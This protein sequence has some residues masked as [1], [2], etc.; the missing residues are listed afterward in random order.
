MIFSRSIQAVALLVFSFLITTGF[1]QDRFAVAGKVSGLDGTAL[2]GASVAIHELQVGMITDEQ[3]RFRF[4]QL[5]PGNYHLHV[6]YLGYESAVVDFRILNEDLVLTIAMHPTSLE[7]KEIVV[8]DSHTKTREEA[9]S[10]SVEVVDERFLA[11]NREAG[12]VGSLEKI[13]GLNAARIGTGAA[14]P[15]IRGLG[16]NRV[17]VAEN[18]IKQEGQQWGADHGLEIDPFGVG[19]VELIKGPAAVMYGSDAMG[20]VLQL[21]APD[22]PSTGSFRAAMI[23]NG[24]TNTDLLGGSIFAEGNK[25]GNFFRVRYSAKEFGDIRVPADS[26]NYQSFIFPVEAGRLKNTAGSERSWAAD[27]GV[28]REWGVSQLRFSRFEQRLGFFPGA[29]GRPNAL[30]VVDDGDYR[31]VDFPRQEIN[32]SKLIWNTNVQHHGNWLEADF[33]FQQNERTEFDQG[34]DS[35]IALEALDLTLQTFSGNLKYHHNWQNGSKAVYGVSGFY[36]DN[37]RG[38]FDFLIPDFNSYGV[39]GYY[40]LEHQAKEE[41]TVNAGVRVDAGRIDIA[42]FSEDNQGEVLERS[43]DLERQFFNVSGAAGLSWLPTHHLNVKFNAGTSFRYP[44]AAELASNG[45]HHGAFR[46]E[47]G[48][49]DLEAERGYQL[50]LNV[51]YHRKNYGVKLSP[52]FNFFDNY[53]YLGPS[54]RFASGDLGSGHIFQYRQTQAVHTGTELSTDVHLHKHVHLAAVAE[55]VWAHNLEQ[56]IP[57]PLIPPFKLLVEA[58]YEM[59]SLLKGRIKSAYLRLGTRMASAQN[60]VDRNEDPTESYFLVDASAGGDWKLGEREIAIFL[61]VRNML[62]QTYFDH[63]SQFRP[64]GLPGPGRNVNISIQ[65]PLVTIKSQTPINYENA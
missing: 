51:N 5:K 50:D 9:G 45:E 65:I 33:G 30:S 47:Q 40:F 38:G 49:P 64:L 36:K 55:Y 3:G 46:F 27:V 13:P 7:F 8:E 24:Q 44:T 39:G 2:D 53:I 52:F 42:A 22:P 35:S 61:Q 23:A 20:G 28:S 59:P 29:H 43:P 16:A 31:N 56:N 32:H 10:Q 11:E 1:A 14:K 15:I 6:T 12:L 41:L 18:G 62:D 4:E 17:L 58:G 26:F 63:L 37:S 48:D 21:F 57:L 60:R 54:G 19:R 25:G 34:A